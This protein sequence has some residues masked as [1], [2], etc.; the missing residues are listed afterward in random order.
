MSGPL[1][2]TIAAGK[3][4]AQPGPGVDPDGSSEPVEAAF[5]PGTGGSTPVDPGQ[6]GAEPDLPPLRI[7]FGPGPASGTPTSGG[8][9]PNGTAGTSSRPG[10]GGSTGSDDR[11][12]SD[13]NTDGPGGNPTGGPAAPRR[14]RTGR[15]PHPAGGP[16]SGPST[17]SITGTSRPGRITNLLRRGRATA[18]GSPT[19]RIAVAKPSRA[20]RPGRVAGGPLLGGL[21]SVL[22][23]WG[24]ALAGLLRSGQGRASR[25]TPE[26]WRVIAILAFGAIVALGGQVDLAAPDPA[27]TPPAAAPA[28]AAT[29]AQRVLDLADSQVGTVEGRGGGTPYHRNYGIA[30]DQ[31]W[32]AVFVWDMFREAGAATLIGPKTAYT[33]T[34]ANWFRQRGQWSDTPTVGALVFYDWPS[35]S[36]NRIQHVG[37]VESIGPNTIQTIEA[38]TSSGVAGSQD[39]GG[40]VWRRT[41]PRNGS[42]VGYGLPAYSLNHQ[43]P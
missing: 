28:G 13:P 25:L 36:R 29:T 6:P 16:S 2:L 1:Q 32:C 27:Q 22:A 18:S 24:S 23:G 38:N 31:P 17:A 19:G 37:I 12:G 3:V 10:V 41:R 40:G 26:T 8:P 34:L 30:A 5:G 21:G 35:D 9:P 42:I 4:P 39:N 43:Q 11:P 7:S 33:P 15:S 14:R 20:P